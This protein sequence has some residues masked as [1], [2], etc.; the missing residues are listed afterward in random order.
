MSL[1]VDGTTTAAASS[2]SS[3]RLLHRYNQAKGQRLSFSLALP[4]KMAAGGTMTSRTLYKPPYLH[5]RHILGCSKAG[6]CTS[7]PPSIVSIRNFSNSGIRLTHRPHTNHAA[8]TT[9]F[10]NTAA[11]LGGSCGFVKVDILTL[12]KAFST[13]QHTCTTPKCPQRLAKP[14][15]KPF[16]FSHS[17]FF[18][19]HV[20]RK[21]VTWNRKMG[22]F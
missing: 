11:S 15:L 2:Y 22:E 14:N 13:R 17:C 12:Q 20:V 5:V 18:T 4:L 16:L 7:D 1:K 3:C 21:D 8:L 6:G 9:I 19:K 10:L